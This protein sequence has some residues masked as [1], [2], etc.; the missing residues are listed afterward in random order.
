MD[1]VGGDGGDGLERGMMEDGMWLQKAFSFR[2]RTTFLCLALSRLFLF[3][4]SEDLICSMLQKR[5][6]PLRLHVA[7]T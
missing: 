1:T 3:L 2:V 5:K 4:V 6:L 7:L